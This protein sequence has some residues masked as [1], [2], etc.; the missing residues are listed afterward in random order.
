MVIKKQQ[1][2]KREKMMESYKFLNDDMVT[3]GNGSGIKDALSTPSLSDSS[4]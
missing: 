1:T 2:D 4:S 3:S